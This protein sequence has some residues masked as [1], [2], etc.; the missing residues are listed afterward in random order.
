MRRSSA[1]VFPNVLNF[2][3]FLKAVEQRILTLS[4]LDAAGGMVSTL[5]NV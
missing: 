1:T 3:R 2:L 4:I 5:R